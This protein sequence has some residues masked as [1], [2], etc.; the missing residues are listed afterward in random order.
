MARTRLTNR[1]Q[2]IWAY[3]SASVMRFSDDNRRATAKPNKNGPIVVNYSNRMKR[4]WESRVSNNVGVTSFDKIPALAN[5]EGNLTQLQIQKEPSYDRKNPPPRHPHRT[6]RHRC[7]RFY[8]TYLRHEANHHRVGRRHGANPTPIAATLATESSAWRCS[9][10][11]PAA[12][13][14]ID[15]FGFEVDDVKE[16]VERD[17]SVLPRP[18][19]HAGV[20][21][22]SVRRH[23][24]AG[25]DGNAVRSIAKGPGERARRLCDETA[26]ISRAGSITLRS[27]P[28]NRTRVAEFYHQGPGAQ[29]RG[30]R[31]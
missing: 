8:Q 30:R 10:S 19:A 2:M 11:A 1:D 6:L 17:Q 24:S 16:A 20:N 3:Y 5:L 21:L 25:S 22:C 13:I 26:G 15:H 27:A 18:F 4:S 7:S 14:G 31:R 28:E 12:V 29:R 9:P 23:A